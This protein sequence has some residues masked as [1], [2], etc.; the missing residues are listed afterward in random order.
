[1]FFLEIVRIVKM[2]FLEI[3]AFAVSSEVGFFF[4]RCSN[5]GFRSWRIPLDLA[6]AVVRDPEAVGNLPLR[7]A[8]ATRT[9][10]APPAPPGVRG[11]IVRF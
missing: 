2:F 7:H 3:V 9:A 1:M 5:F 11:R 4:A 10:V 8:P 6:D